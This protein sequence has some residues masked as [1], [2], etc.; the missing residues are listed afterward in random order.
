MVPLLFDAH[1]GVGEEV[2][3]TLRLF[4]L[5]LNKTILALAMV[6]IFQRGGEKL[7][8]PG[9]GLETQSFGLHSCIKAGAHFVGFAM[10]VGKGHGCFRYL[11]WRAQGFY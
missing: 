2:A 1:S 8:L 5:C 6:G 3:K 9:V 7:V 11:R 4:A 10:E